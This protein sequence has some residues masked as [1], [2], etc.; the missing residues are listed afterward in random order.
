MK[1]GVIGAGVVGTATGKC[2]ESRHEVHYYDK[3]KPRFQD[4]SYIAEDSEIAFICVPTPMKLSGEID[5]SVINN[6]LEYLLENVQIV[7]RNPRDLIV[8]IRSTVVPGT[9]DYFAQKFPFEFAVNPEFLREK[10]AE[11]DMRNTKRIVIGTNSLDVQEKLVEMYK[12][13]FPN[14]EYTLED[15]KT[16]EMIKYSKNAFLA[17]QIAIA[18][19]IWRICDVIGV[20]YDAVKEALLADER[21]GR[22][23]TVPGHDGDYGFG[24]KCLPKDLNALIYYA[25]EHQYRAYL[26]EEVWRSNMA[27][28]KNQDWLSIPGATSNG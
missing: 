20:N 2:L 7:E 8:T 21:I 25:R 11:E 19:E 15:T 3:F 24:G 22:N 13:V 18:N 17:S 6:S 28:R 16:A 5:N 9:T 14:A 4:I 10:Y 26:L 23:I 1:I 27:V 12:K